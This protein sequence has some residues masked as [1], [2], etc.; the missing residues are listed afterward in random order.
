MAL[1]PEEILLGRID[2]N[3]NLPRCKVLY[4]LHDPKVYCC[5]EAGHTDEKHAT[6][7]GRQLLAWRRWNGILA[8]SPEEPRAN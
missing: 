7:A 4:R 6:R 2:F 5:L 3:A 8:V 1:T